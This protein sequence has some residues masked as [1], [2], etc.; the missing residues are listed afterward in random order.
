MKYNV[1]VMFED[2]IEADSVDEV[3]H[4]FYELDEWFIDKANIS[5]K[6]LK[7]EETE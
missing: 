2:D 5:I 3:L 6:K 1:T 7:I 4:I